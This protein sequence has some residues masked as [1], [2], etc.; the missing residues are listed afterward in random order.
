VSFTGLALVLWGAFRVEGSSSCP[1][2]AEV[3]AQLKAQGVETPD[4]SEQRIVLEDVP[5]GL[6]FRL[7]D[8]GGAA[9]GQRT[10]APSATC[11]ERA[12]AVATLVGA[13]EWQRPPAP[14]NRTPREAPGPSAV[15]RPRLLKPARPWE[16]GL[17]ASASLGVAGLSPGGELFGSVGLGPTGWGADLALLALG[18]QDTPFAGGTVFERVFHQILERA[19]QF[20]A[21]AEHDQWF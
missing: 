6:S 21:F 15:T 18:S 9:L 5:E 1:S 20:V 14:P 3:A 10:F 13:W 11:P 4:G 2:P 12:L 17:G 16:V 19:D 7:L 8:V